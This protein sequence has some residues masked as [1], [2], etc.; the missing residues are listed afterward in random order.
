MSKAMLF[1]YT[2]LKEGVKYFDYESGLIYSSG[3][4]FLQIVIRGDRGVHKT[5]PIER[6]S[7]FDVDGEV[8][9]VSKGDRTDSELLSAYKRA[10][11]YA[12]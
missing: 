4:E 9:I 2:P 12:D 6:E 7:R 3:W 5:Y 1:P 8:V 10:V 11:M